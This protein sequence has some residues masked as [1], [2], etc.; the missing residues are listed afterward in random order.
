MIARLYEDAE[1]LQMKFTGSYFRETKP[2]INIKRYEVLSIF[3][4][5]PVFVHLLSRDTSAGL[6][7]RLQ[8]G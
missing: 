6:L 4:T 8:C 1:V 3:I 7:M 2:T 5:L